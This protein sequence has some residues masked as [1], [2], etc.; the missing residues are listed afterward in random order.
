MIPITTKSYGHK[1]ICWCGKISTLIS[2]D[3]EKSSGMSYKNNGTFE[4]LKCVFRGTSRTWHT[5]TTRSVIKDFCQHFNLSRSHTFIIWHFSLHTSFILLL[6]K[7]INETEKYFTQ[8]LLSIPIKMDVGILYLFFWHILENNKQA[9]A[10][11]SK[12]C[13]FNQFRHI[14]RVI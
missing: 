10:F 9:N 3:R 7:I 5:Y 6:P 12:I 2:C 8:P 11:S 1:F 13:D 14:N 4:T